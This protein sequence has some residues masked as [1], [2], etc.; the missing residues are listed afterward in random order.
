MSL[1]CFDDVLS[2]YSGF[3]AS[4]LSDEIMDS[5]ITLRVHCIEKNKESSVDN[6]SYDFY[7]KSPLISWKYDRV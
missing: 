4:T 6:V 5:Y 7:S 3:L 1:L 2:P